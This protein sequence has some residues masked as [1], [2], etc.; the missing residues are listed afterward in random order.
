MRS[1]PAPEPLPVT[2][3]PVLLLVAVTGALV[4]AGYALRRVTR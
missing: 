1:S 2:G 3:R 4:I